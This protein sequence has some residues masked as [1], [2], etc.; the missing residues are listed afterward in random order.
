MEDTVSSSEMWLLTG[1]NRSHRDLRS[2]RYCGDTLV[3]EE[4]SIFFFY[5]VSHVPAYFIRPAS[6]ANKFVFEK[7]RA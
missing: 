6:V 4:D 3:L 2:S 5:Q 1:V 7:K